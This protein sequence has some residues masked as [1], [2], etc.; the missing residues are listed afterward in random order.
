MISNINR[1]WVSLSDNMSQQ[2]QK[3]LWKVSFNVSCYQSIAPI[4]VKPALK[5]APP[6][7]QSP[8]GKFFAT[9]TTWTCPRVSTATPIGQLRKIL[10]AA[11]FGHTAKYGGAFRL[12]GAIRHKY[13]SLRRRGWCLEDA[14]VHLSKRQSFAGPAC[15]SKY[16]V[17][18]NTWRATV[19]S[20]FVTSDPVGPKM[21]M[22][23]R[24]IE[25]RAPPKHQRQDRHT[26]LLPVFVKLS[27]KKLEV[28]S[29]VEARGKRLNISSSIQLW[30][31]SRFAF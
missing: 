6:S 5:R 30:R 31:L 25:R 23:L 13:G 8:H 17:G 27:Q 26:P 12:I 29:Y 9:T 20:P 2:L 19:I 3:W 15:P 7:V 11:K 14:F 4:S 22:S 18:H 21:F 28:G 16:V 10:D 24:K 1:K